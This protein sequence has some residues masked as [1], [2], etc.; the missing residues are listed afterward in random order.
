[1]KRQAILQSAKHWLQS[2]SEK[3][4]LRGYCK[5]YAEDKICGITEFRMLGIQISK[6]YETQIKKTTAAEQKARKLRKEK[7][8]SEFNELLDE[9]SDENFAFIACYISNGVPLALLTRKWN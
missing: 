2:Y 1:M 6:E 7:R 3:H 8:E 9:F 5:H 4:I